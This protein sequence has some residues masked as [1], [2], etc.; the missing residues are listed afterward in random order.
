MN[1]VYSLMFA[2]VGGQGSLLIAELTSIAAAHA[3]YDIKQTEVHGVS[4]R[5]GSVET[6]VRFGQKV[7][8]P[9]VTPGEAAAVIA[10][11]KLEALRF[12]HFVNPE[13]GIVLVNEYEIIPGS[14][15]GAADVYPHES[16]EYLR[17]KGLNVSALP[18]SQMAHDLGDGRMANVIMI[19]ALSTQ[20]PIPEA[21]WQKALRTRLPSR[22]L[23]GNILAFATGQQ[24]LQKEPM[25]G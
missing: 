15:S 16:I 1:K 5:G 11:E 17:E 25:G 10:L 4:Q 21:S 18:A 6:H 12:A 19:G 2:G 8:S 14:V 3:G 23:K 7:H 20:L 22:Y 24:A 13:T 9:I